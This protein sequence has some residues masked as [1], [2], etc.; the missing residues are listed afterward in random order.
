MLQKLSALSRPLCCG[1]GGRFSDAELDSMQLWKSDGQTA[2]EIHKR[3]AKNRLKKRLGGP[4]LTTVRRAIKG[5]TH[6]RAKHETRGHKRI[7]TD[8]NLTRFT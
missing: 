8:T 7:L 3:L 2:S 1:V 6:Q 5:K 4:D